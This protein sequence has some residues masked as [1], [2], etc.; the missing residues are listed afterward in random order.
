MDDSAPHAGE[1]AEGLG[2]S[3]EKRIPFVQS[4]ICS[5]DRIDIMT[6]SRNWK[7]EYAALRDFAAAHPEIRIDQSEISIPKA[8]RDDFYQRFDDVRKAV[9]NGHYPALCK[10]AE[11]LRDNFVRTEGEVIELLGLDGIVI[12]IDLYS[13]LHDPKK[14]LMRALY[15]KLFD[16]L[17]GKM[18]IE[19]FEQQAG[20]DLETSA[21][22]LFRL[23]YEPWIFLSLIKL[24]EPDKAFMVD[25]D[26]EDED[27]MV[28]V[29][30]KDISFGR[31]A[32]HGYFRIPEIVLHSCKLDKYVAVKAALAREIQSYVVV[33][34]TPVKR[35]RRAGDSSFALD[36]RVMLLYVMANAEE[37]PIVAN[38]GEKKI[39][40]PDLVVEC[41]GMDEIKDPDIMEQVERRHDT[42]KPKIGTFLAVRDPLTE[43]SVQSPGEK[44]YSVP[45]G[46]DSS[47]LLPILDRLQTV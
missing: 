18:T 41:I 27:K 45:A 9:V 16:L 42:L 17:Q 6:I 46:F 20:I 38:L 40:S 33:Q 8:I 22:E 14:G 43:L 29:E 26:P 36:Y 32:L 28:L 5:L 3:I 21:A 34:D 44:I 4:C 13:F 47:R 30:L 15:T 11:T 39:S 10:A 24:L 1:G 7:Q 12:P 35:K 31:Q 2:Q 19:S 25:L 37:I 23:G